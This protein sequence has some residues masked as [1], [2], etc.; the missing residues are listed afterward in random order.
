MAKL[1]SEMVSNIE[2][3]LSSIEAK[4]ETKAV[5]IHHEKKD[6]I[7]ESNVMKMRSLK[8]RT[9]DVKKKCF[10][11]KPRCLI[12]FPAVSDD[13]FVTSSLDGRVQLWSHSRKNTVTSALFGSDSWVEDLKI[14]RSVVC[15][16]SPSY[17]LLGLLCNSENKKIES[18]QIFVKKATKA[19]DALSTPIIYSKR[20]PHSKG[21]TCIEIVPTTRTATSSSSSNEFCFVSGSCDSNIAIWTGSTLNP[22]E[23]IS[24]VETPHTAA[25]H[26]LLFHQGSR[27]L[28]S[29]GADCKLCS[30]DLNKADSTAELLVDLKSQGR[31]G[32]ILS[33]SRR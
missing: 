5:Q 6:D 32:A 18:G 13:F 3:D 10:S 19:E 24:L 30:L 21:I 11:R 8:L 14:C 1:F 27:R 9:C 22:E 15:N 16:D 25:I 26:A 31:V 28:L 2:A 20:N 17:T 4:I 23:K 7:L 33:G 29:G 12:K